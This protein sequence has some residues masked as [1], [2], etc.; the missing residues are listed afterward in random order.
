ML[1]PENF[2]H[3]RNKHISG[4]FFIISGK[5][6]SYLGKNVTYIQKIILVCPENFFEMTMPPP[7]CL[8]ASY[9]HGVASPTIQSRYAN[10]AMFINYQ[11]NQFLKKH[12]TF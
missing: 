10:I 7:Q 11:H 8:E 1:I 6:F 2:V 3:F 4:K 5:C 12:F 9:A